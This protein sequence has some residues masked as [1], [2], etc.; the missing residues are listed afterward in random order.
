VSNV[1]LLTGLPGTGKLTVANQLVTQMS[2][3]GVGVKLVDNH[4]WNNVIFELID[5]DGERPLPPVVWDRVFE[6]GEAV[7]LTIE[8]LSPTEWSFVLTA[9]VESGDE[10][11][12]ERIA[13]L[14]K[15][16][17]STFTVVVL[18]CELDALEERIVAPGRAEN[19]KMTSVAGIRQLYER[20]PPS[21]DGYDV[22]TI[23]NTN[24][25]PQE[26][27]AQILA[28]VSLLNP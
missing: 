12:L 26:V 3:D 9:D 24:L 4:Y 15:R 17:G 20:E 27:A 18:H 16:R 1:V 23:D 7:W 11:F 13:T 19:Q 21:L 25:P 22:I 8:E 2:D 10:W 28:E 5:P 14:A 6:V